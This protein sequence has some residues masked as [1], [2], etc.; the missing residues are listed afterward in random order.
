MGK[1]EG[2]M[3]GVDREGKRKEREREKWGKRREKGEEEGRGEVREEEDDLVGKLCI[4]QP[5][6]RQSNSLLL[7]GQVTRL[8]MGLAGLSV[9][10]FSRAAYYLMPIWK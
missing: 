2:G 1:E 8:R 5:I 9:L 3:N 7:A 10:W 6:L 4:F